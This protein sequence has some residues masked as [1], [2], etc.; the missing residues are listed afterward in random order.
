[1]RLT[2]FGATGGVGSEVVG[3]AL[4][5]GHHV[6]AVTRDPTRVR[7]SH[8]RLTLATVPV[9][10]EPGVLL[11]A[12]D[13]SDAVL[14]AVGPRRRGD[15]GITHTITRAIAAAMDRVGTKRIV[16]VSAAP[17]APAHPDD[18]LV[19]RKLAT[20]LVSA[21]FRPIYDDLRAM[22]DLLR[23]SGL[24]WTTI[25]PPRL[26]NGAARGYR[27]SIDGNL[28]HGSKVSRADIAQSMLDVLPSRE[29]V[30][31]GVGVAW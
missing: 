23:G 24:E 2:I 18:S 27:L 12:V 30:R 17:L 11:E 28:P 10:D 21:L 9:M 16:A 25:R 7:I 13:R 19:M 29:A 4:A 1:M 6:A 22:E 15:A 31:R 3:R 14:S 20:P 8:P 26:V 5:A